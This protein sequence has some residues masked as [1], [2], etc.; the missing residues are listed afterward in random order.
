MHTNHVVKEEGVITM[1]CV[2]GLFIMGKLVSGNKLCNP[3]VFSFIEDG[4]KMQL[5][6][7]PSTPIFITLG[8]DGFRYQISDQD[9]NLLN[10]YYRVTGPEDME[11]TT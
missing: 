3:R 1:V 9:K 8:M 11:P 2:A 10:L 7:L 6:P 4:K 5:A